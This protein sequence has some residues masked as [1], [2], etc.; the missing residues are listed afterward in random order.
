MIR[1]T[2]CAGL[3]LAA[4][5]S[6]AFTAE[7]VRGVAK[8]AKEVGQGVVQG[9]AQAG[10]GVAQGTVGVAKGAATATKKTGKGLWCIATLG[11]GC[12]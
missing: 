12:N 11:F 6:P 5:A 8:G 3:I 1:T 2:L 9:S 4:A 10:K 7:P